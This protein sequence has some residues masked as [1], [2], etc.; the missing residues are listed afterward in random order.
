M[1]I[2]AEEKQATRERIE[3]AA[4]DSTMQLAA[5]RLLAKTRGFEQRGEI[6]AGA[7]AERLEQIDQILGADELTLGG[8]TVGNERPLGQPGETAVEEMG[9]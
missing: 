1:R 6:D 7:N 8:P 2:T 3:A 9:L 5:E 4:R